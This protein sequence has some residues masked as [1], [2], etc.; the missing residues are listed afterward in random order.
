LPPVEIDLVQ[1]TSGLTNRSPITAAEVFKMQA[2]Q[3]G[4]PALG[5]AGLWLVNTIAHS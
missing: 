1:T 5:F 3:L 4:V 2:N